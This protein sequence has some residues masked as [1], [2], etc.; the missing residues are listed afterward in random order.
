MRIGDRIAMMRDGRIV[1]IGTAEQILNEPA[2]DYVAQFVKEA[3]RGRLVS[4]SRVMQP[5][6]AP[7]PLATTVPMDAKLEAVAPQVLTAEQPVTVVDD[8][9]R[10]VG[11]LTRERL[12]DHLFPHAPAT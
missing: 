1:Q 9:G 12:L 10:P 7:A 5:L 8:Q 3:P 2:N 6:N 11:V 4:V